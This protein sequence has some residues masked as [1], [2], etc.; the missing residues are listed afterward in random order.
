MDAI[1]HHVLVFSGKGQSTWDVFV[2]SLGNIED[3]S[4]GDITA[5]SYHNYL[6]DVASLVELKV[7][8][9]WDNIRKQFYNI[10]KQNNTK[11]KS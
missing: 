3:G 4:T 7:C 10:T 9:H 5:D 6:K 1:K 8:V 11:I 2:R